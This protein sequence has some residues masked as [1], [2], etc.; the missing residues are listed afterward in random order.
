MQWNKIIWQADPFWAKREKSWKLERGGAQVPG[1]YFLRKGGTN[2]NTLLLDSGTKN[3]KFF[4]V[5]KVRGKEPSQGPINHGQRW[6]LSPI[7]TVGTRWETF[8]P[9]YPPLL[10]ETLHH[11][12]WKYCIYT[13]VKPVDI[14][15]MAPKI[16]GFY[17]SKKQK[18][19]TVYVYWPFNICCAFFTQLTYLRFKQL[20]SRFRRF[21][22]PNF[23]FYKAY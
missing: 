3:E 18:K 10:T 20:F 6:P 17:C 15:S 7:A 16:F 2:R 19:E 1:G 4:G 12:R 5:A 22:F 21:V 9:P 14:P 13:A 11:P 23:F 8:F